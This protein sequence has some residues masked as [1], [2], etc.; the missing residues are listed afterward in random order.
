VL[1]AE[2]AQE[3]KKTRRAAQRRRGYAQVERLR[4]QGLRRIPEIP[5]ASADEIQAF[6]EI[7]VL[8]G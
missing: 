6:D 4:P 5:L 1:E 2:A 3:T 7:E 8:D